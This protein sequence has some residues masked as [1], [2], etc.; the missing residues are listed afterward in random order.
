MTLELLYRDGT[1][2]TVLIKTIWQN[3]HLG[4][5]QLYYE[6]LID[7]DG[8][9]TFIPMANLICWRIKLNS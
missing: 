5:G 7:E 9:G 3:M 6:H 2:T 4:M 1:K 8:K